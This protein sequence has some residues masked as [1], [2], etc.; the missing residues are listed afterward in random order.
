MDSRVERLE[1]KAQKKK[2]LDKWLDAKIS[3]S[4]SKSVAHDASST[5]ASAL[6]G[7]T[8]V[9]EEPSAKYETNASEDVEMS[10]NIS[11]EP[12]SRK[13]VE[14]VVLGKLVV[15]TFSE[16]LEVPHP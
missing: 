12:T 5:A 16:E 14:A 3:A 13:G 10:T 1:G 7:A 8:M 11:I 6:V 4:N 15:S 2:V 9:A